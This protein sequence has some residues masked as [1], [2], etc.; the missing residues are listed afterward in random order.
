MLRR[1]LAIFE[2]KSIEE[3]EF[4]QICLYS[5]RWWLNITSSYLTIDELVQKYGGHERVR[6]NPE[7]ALQVH[8]QIEGHKTSNIPGA[9]RKHSDGK[10]TLQTNALASAKPESMLDRREFLE[11]QRPLD[12]VV[13]D[14][15]PYYENK[16]FAQIKVI[17]DEISKSTLQI[18][19]RLEAG[20]HDKIMHPDVRHVWKDMVSFN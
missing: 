7:I 20:S 4:G 18:L 11:L 19:S 3:R 8:A 9:H 15:L 6:D 5:Y 10:P 14:S 13:A 12:R 17:K 2:H 16:L 1:V